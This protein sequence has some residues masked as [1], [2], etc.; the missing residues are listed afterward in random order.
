M[1]QL[2]LGSQ[3]AIAPC[4]D[5]SKLGLL[6]LKNDLMILRNFSHGINKEGY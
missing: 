4:V 2:H 6:G 1:F 3:G 5:A